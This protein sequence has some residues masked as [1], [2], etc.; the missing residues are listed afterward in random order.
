MSQPRRRGSLAWAVAA[1]APAGVAAGLA[2]DATA[3]RAGALPEVAVLLP[4]GPWRLGL[5]AHL[6]AFA[7]AG[8][9]F[10]LLVRRLRCSAGELVFMGVAYGALC[11]WLGPLTL[12]PLLAGA[13]PA[14]DL[15]AAQRQFPSLVGHLLYGAA[16]ALAFVM[17]HGADDP[18]GRAGP[19][20]VGALLHGALAGAAAAVALRA[21]LDGRSVAVAFGP[22]LGAAQ[23]ALS[24]RPLRGAGAALVR[25][26]AYG[27]VAWLV[28]GLT[29]LPLLRGG[30]LAWSVAAARASFPSLPA[31]LLLGVLA[32]LLRALLD[33][34]A[35]LLSS[36]HLRAYPGASAGS[37]WL[38]A[39]LRGAAAGLVGGAAISQLMLRGGVPAVAQLLTGSSGLLA[40]LA[41]NLA[42]GVAIGVSYGLLFRGL[43]QDVSCAL[44][45][46]LAYGLLWWI[47]GPLTLL[48][49]LLGG[50]P[51]WTAAAAAGA[52]AALAGHLVYGACLGV[53]FHLL[54]APFGVPWL[55]RTRAEALRARRRRDQLLASAPALSALLVT[56]LVTVLVVV[57]GAA[58]A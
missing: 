10:G 45:W 23:A 43:G 39:A 9:G 2:L 32:A 31:W 36:E 30:S 29:A 5:V 47:L 22:L 40:G 44:G 8:A 41:I 1:G 35:P 48:P 15:Q 7:V 54:E 21:A 28:G 34:L 53:A 11:W 38:A 26:Q 37:A 19:A 20:G 51:Q 17:L 4:A 12:W 52:V 42:I 16:T 50:Q 33:R 13:V 14:W 25:G 27:F 58:P 18:D 55:P 3:G 46:G 57:S 6:A 56:L 49:V 24:P